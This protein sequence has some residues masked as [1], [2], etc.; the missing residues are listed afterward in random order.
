[1]NEPL[2]YRMRPKRLEDVIGQKHL[3]G[4]KSILSRM[5][6]SGRLSSIILYG[7]PGTGKTS[8]SRAISGSANI[9][10]FELNA[11]SAG[12]KDIEKVA[13]EAE[14]QPVMLFIDE[15]HRF[16]KVQ[17][18]TLL[19]Y[20]ENGKF[21]LIGSTTESVMHEI[22]PALRSRC[23]L[24]ELKPLEVEEIEMGIERAISDK[25]NGLGNYKVKVSEEAMKYFVY[26]CGGDM[27]S[28]LNAVEL[29]VLSTEPNE[30]G[31]IVITLQDAEQSLQKKS[32]L[33]DKSGS[34]F[35]STISA[36]QKSVRGSDTDAALHYLAKL[37][38]AGDLKTIVRRTRVIAWEDI[39]LA[40]PEAALIASKCCDDAEQLG[41]PEARIPL[42][43]AVVTLCLSAKS[44]TAYKALDKAIMDVKN[45]NI[46][47]I[48]K[49]LRDNHFKG[50]KELGNGIGYIYPH[51]VDGFVKQQYLPDNLVNRRYYEPKIKGKEKMLA[52]YYEKIKEL[53]DN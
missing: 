30:E 6:K 38:E 44:N 7:P 28:A 25:E 19:P 40:N 33:M 52:I 1:M 23:Q 14:K 5:V 50:A 47:D 45:G 18:D 31:E 17:Q 3:V 46:G 20:T 48:P 43:V 24:F 12:K 8:V 51:D 42:S 37:I 53:Q 34:E 49:H 16:T 35:Y 27:R 11:V 26:G 29:A 21:I 39:G 2:A 10:F 22:V 41:F 9:P 32:F 36:Y 13:K 4:E 15:I